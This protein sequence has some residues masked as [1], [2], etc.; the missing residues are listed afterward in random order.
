VRRLV[1]ISNPAKKELNQYLKQYT[2]AVKRNN[3]WRKH[4]LITDHIA[5]VLEKSSESA[6]VN[7]NSAIVKYKLHLH[8]T[9]QSPRI[10]EAKL[11]TLAN[12]FVN[13]FKRNGLGRKTEGTKGK[14]L[15]K[16]LFVIMHTGSLLDLRHN[17]EAS[18][19][20]EELEIEAEYRGTIAHF[21]KNPGVAK[22]TSKIIFDEFGKIGE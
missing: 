17:P 18:K 1:Q 8:K 14:M 13:T 20:P 11:R 10:R 2:G 4:P 7:L 5:R 6:K 9:E 15:E 19:T 21:F 3:Y 12:S 16:L 22:D